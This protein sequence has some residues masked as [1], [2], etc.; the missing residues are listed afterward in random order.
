MNIRSFL[1][2]LFGFLKTK[3]EVPKEPVSFSDKP[4]TTITV[5]VDK[6]IVGAVQSL[7]ITESRRI[8]VP[9]SSEIKVTAHRIR[10]DKTRIAEAFARGF[11]SKHSQR[12]PLQFI[13]N[14]VDVITTIQNAWIEDTF[15]TYNTVDWII[16]D[17]IHFVA[18][19]IISKKKD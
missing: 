3:E 18:E 7:S 4:A 8:D 5:W 10:F 6:Q 9:G 19:A 1:S 14:D 15:M 16:A 17:E 13:I 2:R 11:L 12:Y